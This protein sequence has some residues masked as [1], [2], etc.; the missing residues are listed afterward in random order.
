MLDLLPDVAQVYE[1]Y[2]NAQLKRA[3]AKIYVAPDAVDDDETINAALQQ[4]NKMLENNSQLDG[5]TLSHKVIV[6]R[7]IVSGFAIDLN[8]VYV[9]K[10]VGHQVAAHQADE[11]DYI[12]VPQTHV[13]RT[14]WDDNTAT[15]YLRKYLDSLADYD[16]E[17]MRYGV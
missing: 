6:D 12:A 4:A 9:N 13:T 15:E 7:T 16:A 17:E 8:G 14:S 5:Y 1:T 2:V 3:M 11:S 10:A